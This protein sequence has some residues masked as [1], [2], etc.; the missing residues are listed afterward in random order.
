MGGMICITVMILLFKQSVMF[1]A[2]CKVGLIA[3]LRFF[4]KKII[5][6]TTEK[7]EKWITMHN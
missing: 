5:A 4:L 6:Q 3:D 1:N 7:D 2:H